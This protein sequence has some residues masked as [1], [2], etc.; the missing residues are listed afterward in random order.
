MTYE[1]PPHEVNEV[2]DLPIEGLIIDVSKNMRR[3]PTDEEIY[4]MAISLGAVGQMQNVIVV[5]RGHAY[6]LVV[7]YTRAIAIHGYGEKIGIKTIRAMRIAASDEDDARAAENFVRKNPSTYETAKYFSDRYAGRRGSAT[8]IPHLAVIVGKSEDYVRGLLRLFR[9]LPPNIKAAWEADRDQLFTF[10]KL[11]DLV[12]LKQ[13]GDEAGMNARLQEIF[14]THPKRRRGVASKPGYKTAEQHLSEALQG[15]GLVRQPNGML[16]PNPY[17]RDRNKK[18]RAQRMSRRQLENMKTRLASVS[19]DRLT[20]FTVGGDAFHRFVL[21]LLGEAPRSD[22]WSVIY[23]LVGDEGAETNADRAD[24]DLGMVRY[25]QTHDL[26]A[27]S[28]SKVSPDP[29]DDD[30]EP[31]SANDAEHLEDELGHS[32][33]DDDVG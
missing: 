17:L 32:P 2:F 27:I 3:P 14:A 31:A 11:A 15:C 22:A 4:E 16:A 7:G 6:E 12:R 5:W 8:P 1:P 30:R 26:N 24:G 23:Q 20:R 18:R 9:E 29:L 28:A 25:L 33:V 21:A 10:H 13:S 19:P